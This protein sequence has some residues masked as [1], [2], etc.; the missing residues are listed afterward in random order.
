MTRTQK[1]AEDLT[2]LLKARNTLLWITTREEMRAECPHVPKRR[3]SD[4]GT[5]AV[6]QG[7]VSVGVIAGNYRNGTRAG[8]G[9]LIGSIRRGGETMNFAAVLF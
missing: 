2:A 6:V 5:A 4:H 7:P 1:T 9:C 3:R 8:I